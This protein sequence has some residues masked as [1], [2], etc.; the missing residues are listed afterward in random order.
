MRRLLQRRLI[1][2]RRPTSILLS[3]RFEWTK[4]LRVT[5]TIELT[6]PRLRVKQ[7]SFGTDHESACVAATG[8]YDPSVLQSWA[9]LAEYVEPLNHQRRVTITRE[10]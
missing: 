5:D 4:G 3:R 7:M 2:G 9:D 8:G 6:D 1:T 10:W